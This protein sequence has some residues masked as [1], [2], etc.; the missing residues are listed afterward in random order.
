MND[1]KF[2]VQKLRQMVDSR[3]LITLI[4]RD[5][6]KGKYFIDTFIVST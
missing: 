5:D 2:T 6:K 4:A 3:T 1:Y